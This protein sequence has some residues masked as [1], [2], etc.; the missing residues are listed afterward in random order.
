MSSGASSTLHLTFCI[1]IALFLVIV[2]SVTINDIG[3]NL[4]RTAS[5]QNLQPQANLTSVEQLQLM[6]GIS[7][8]IDNVSFS[9]HMASVNGIQMHYVIGGQGDPVVLLHGCPYWLR[10]IP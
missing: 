10:I 8:E 2:T 1:V 5:A 3:L 6:D 9:H 7:F 4:S